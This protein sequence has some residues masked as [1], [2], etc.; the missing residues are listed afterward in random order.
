MFFCIRDEQFSETQE[1]LYWVRPKVHQTHYS[2]R[3]EYYML[4]DKCNSSAVL[5]GFFLG[6]TWMAGIII[7]TKFAVFY[8]N[9]AYC[10]ISQSLYQHLFM[11]AV[12]T[13]LNYLKLSAKFHGLMFQDLF[14]SFHL[15]LAL[16]RYFNR[17]TAPDLFEK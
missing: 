9:F 16:Q 6:Y 7:Q 3:V 4:K 10:F 14:L 13:T 5:Q 8:M 12:F 1:H 2:N 17:L 15:L 11:F